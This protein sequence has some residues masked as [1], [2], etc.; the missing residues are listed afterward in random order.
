MILENYKTNLLLNINKNSVVLGFL[1][2]ISIAF[3]MIFYN[4]HYYQDDIYALFIINSSFN[5]A[6]NWIQNNDVHPPLSYLLNKIIYEVFSS[7]KA[8]LVFSALLNALALA[9]FYKFTQQTITDK[10]AKILLFLFVFLNGGILMWTTS[11]RW[12]AYWVPLAIILYTYILQNQKL[13]T[14]N[15]VVIAVLLSVMTYIGYLTFLFMI[16]VL[17]FIL[18]FRRDSL[19]FKNISLSATIY[20][21]LSSYQIYIFLTVHILNKDSQ[22]STYLA[23][24]LYPIYA[25]VNGGSI[26]MFDYVFIIFLFATLIISLLGLRY[27]VYAKNKIIFKESVIFIVIFIALMIVTQIGL[28]PKSSIFL[29][30]IFYL[31]VAILISYIK[32]VNIKKIYLIF[33]ISV[34]FY[35]SFNL[36]AKQ[37]TMNSTYNLPVTEIIKFLDINSPHI[38][39]SDNSLLL[40]TL[41]QKQYNT[42][43]I[44]IEYKSQVYALLNKITKKVFEKLTNK[45]QNEKIFVKKRT[46]VYLFSLYESVH[47]KRDKA[48]EKLKKCMTDISIKNIGNNKY[49]NM[50]KRLNL[51]FKIYAIITYGKMKHDCS[52]T[53]TS[54]V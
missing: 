36:L 25:M 33:T 45:T 48:Y 52:L 31:V 23:S 10:Y 16:T 5:E 11:V 39:I 12:Y 42:Y 37:N 32:N 43:Y 19:S 54:N 9:Y 18:L 22:V 28:K 34:L 1:L 40:S 13:N 6:L 38:I 2:Y 8:I 49:G 50:G 15:L 21:L 30:P 14:K 51:G 7:F 46:N 27:F 4:Y 41:A 17:I 26:I 53:I 3:T 24:F 20:L 44:Y 29:S 35:S 47:K